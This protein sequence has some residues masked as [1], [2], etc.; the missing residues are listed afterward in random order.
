[1]RR[2]QIC[3]DFFWIAHSISPSVLVPLVVVLESHCYSQ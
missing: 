1:M 3:Y 2:G